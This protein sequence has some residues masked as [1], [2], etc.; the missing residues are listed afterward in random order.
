M[1]A[2]EYEKLIA[3]MKSKQAHWSVC[4]AIQWSHS[5]I[6]WCEHEHHYLDVEEKQLKQRIRELVRYRKNGISKLEG[7]SRH[8]CMCISTTNLVPYPIIHFQYHTLIR[9]DKLAHCSCEGMCD[10]CFHCLADCSEFDLLKQEQEKMKENR[11]VPVGEPCNP[12]SFF[13][14][15]T[16]LSPPGWWLNDLAVC[17]YTCTPHSV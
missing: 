8:V 10:I 2:E 4:V 7:R 16:L 9:I 15:I 13:I 12:I 11:K 14:H 6:G 17:Y 3:S 5:T 1:D